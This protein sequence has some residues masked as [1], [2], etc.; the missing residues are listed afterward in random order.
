[1]NAMMYTRGRP[2]DFDAWREAG[3]EGWGWDDVLPY[4]KRME[5]NERGDVGDPRHR[6]PGQ[7]RRPGRPAAADRARSSRPR[8]RP[9]SPR[10]PDVNSPEQDGVDPDPGLPAQRPPLERRRRL[11]APGGEA[12]EPDREDRRR[13]RSGSSSKATGRPACAGATRA[14]A[15]ATARAPARGDPLRRGDRQPAAADAVGD[16]P[17]RAPAGARRSSP[18]STSPASART[19]RTTPSSPLCFE[20]T[21]AEDLADAEKP[22]RCS[23][24]CSGAAA[25]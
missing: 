6:R 4:F 20:S 9:G 2:L 7:R 11:P 24:G 5:N 12:P 14:A 17:R 19:S 21:V 23:S 18:G 10:N 8:E 25:R 16:R 22:R 1:M 13:R 3:C 15:S